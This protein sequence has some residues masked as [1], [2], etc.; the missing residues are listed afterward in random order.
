[1]NP[2]LRRQVADLSAPF[3]RL[4]AYTVDPGAAALAGA[5]RPVAGDRFG[6]WLTEGWSAANLPDGIAATP[7]AVAALDMPGSAMLMGP[8]MDAARHRRM[9]RA[10]ADAGI[11][12]IM[13]MDH[14][15]N[16]GRMLVG[17]EG[18]LPDLICVPD[19]VG[20]DLLHE[21]LAALGVAAADVAGRV[22]Q[23]PHLGIAAVLDAM[24]A[25]PDERRRD[26]RAAL[27][28]GAARVVAL[29]LDPT[30]E[31]QREEAG[32]DAATVL[33][34]LAAR[35]AAGG[36]GPVVL[37]RPHPRQDMAVL[38]SLLDAWRRNGIPHRLTAEPPER[39]LAIAD[40][41]WGLTSVV[42]VMAKAAGLPIKSLQ[43]GRNAFGAGLSNRHIE[44]FVELEV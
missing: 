5:I 16:Y 9:V 35:L 19:Q 10:C 2:T 1:M 15:K 33:N 11:T 27:A 43:F 42:L 37:I 39:L 4:H 26:L 14:W 32:Y 8:Q 6:R 25:I 31:R 23:L 34:G 3:S 24:A 17:P 18:P 13:L 21:E 36:P 44:P 12:T 20:L 38:D 28:P 40:E 41:V 7:E 22:R 29:F 30:D